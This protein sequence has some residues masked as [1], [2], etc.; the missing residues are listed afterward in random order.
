MP[1]NGVIGRVIG[2][3]STTLRVALDIGSQGFTKAGPLG[4]QTVGV[5][6]SYITVPAGTHRVVAIVTSVSIVAHSGN[7]EG[8]SVSTQ[9][10][11]SSYELEATVV[12]RFEEDTFKSGLTGYP[13]LY[14]PVHSAS[15]GEV[16]KI[17]LPKDTRSLR[18][19]ESAV[20][21]EQDVCLDINLLLGHHCAVVG[22]TGSGKSCTVMGILDGLIEQSIPSGHIVIFDVNGE[23]AK[24]FDSKSSRGS[25]TRTVVLG[26]KLGAGDGLFLPHW[27]MNNEENLALMRASEGVQA[28]ILQRSVADARAASTSISQDMNRLQAVRTSIT[29]IEALYNGINAQQDIRTLLISLGKVLGAQ[30][31]KSG[32]CQK[33]WGEMHRITQK[34]FIETNLLNKQWSRL[35]TEQNILLID[36]CDNLR[37]QTS[38]AFGVLGM[39]SSSGTPDFDAPVFYSLQS[40]CDYFLPNRVSIE[41][42]NDNKIGS[43]VATLQMRLSRLLADGRY[44]FMTRVEQ[45]ADPL[46]SYLRLLMGSDPTRGNAASDWPGAEEYRAQAAHHGD[47]PS[48]TIFDLSLVASDVLENVTALLGRL[49]FDFAVRSTPRAEHPMLLVLEEAHRFVPARHDTRAGES[50]STAVFERIAKE[51]RKFGVSLLLASQRPSDLSETVVAQCGTVIA[52]RLTHEA[53]QNLLRHATAL[54]SRPLLDQLSGLAQQH[55][56]VTG[57]SIG[58]PAAVRIRDIINPPE[59]KDPDFLAKWSS[60]SSQESLDEDIAR[61]VREWQGLSGDGNLM[62]DSLNTNMYPEEFYCP[63]AEGF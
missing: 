19:G 13:P 36:F 24:A 32:S 7:Q 43:Y 23:Y 39:G 8:R 30:T 33:H 61:I 12:G 6:N 3:Q 50:R 54:S 53:D 2:V 35:T 34:V 47:G 38:Q 51:G 10:D 9:D 1:E 21:S 27:F 37:Q 45:H 42:A 57:V 28:P 11:Q 31:Q 60:P 17:F 14:A 56:L 41:Q 20:S 55:A 16:A 52:H 18:L 40:L 4:L 63:P 5:V 48:V 25:S 15:S 46:G 49:L 59:S 58:V 26:P 29:N 62:T 22:S 44:D